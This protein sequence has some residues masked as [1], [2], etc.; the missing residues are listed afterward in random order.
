MNFA[1]VNLLAAIAY[2]L[3]IIAF[4]LAYIIFRGEGK[5]SKR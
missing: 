3:I 4:A 1:Q 2:I 5:S